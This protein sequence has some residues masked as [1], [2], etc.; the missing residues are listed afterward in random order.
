[1]ISSISPSPVRPVQPRDNAS[2]YGFLGQDSLSLSIAD[3][4]NTISASGVVGQGFVNLQESNGTLMGDVSTPRGI[5][6][7]DVQVQDAGN[8]TRQ[9]SGV[10]GDAFVNLQESQGNIF[11]MVGN[12][13]VNVSASSN[14]SGTSFDGIVSGAG[15]GG[16]VNVTVSGQGAVCDPVVVLLGLAS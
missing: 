11:G 10:L 6:T 4:N 16:F 13:S 9:F 15:P 2:A 8:G 12:R 3:D 7:V 5:A 1:M 14:G